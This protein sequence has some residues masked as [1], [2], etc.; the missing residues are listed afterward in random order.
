MRVVVE[1]VM[2]AVRHVA[3]RCIG[4]L[5]LLRASVGDS[6]YSK[7]FLPRESKQSNPIVGISSDPCTSQNASR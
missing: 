4:L 3:S 6:L 2:E 7:Y 1:V 5:D